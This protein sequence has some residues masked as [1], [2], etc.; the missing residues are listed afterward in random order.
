MAKSYNMG[1]SEHR[2]YLSYEEER[3][4]EK[5]RDRK[6]D[7]EILFCI[8]THTLSSLLT[9]ICIGF[10]LKEIGWDSQTTF[11]NILLCVIISLSFCSFVILPIAY[12]LE[13]NY[14]SIKKYRY[15]DVF[16]IF[17]A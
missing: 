13:E 16:N 9:T 17:T 10:F 1:W 2:P 15:C 14:Q 7:T 5:E 4:L 11:V 6:K 8:R 3:R 12:G